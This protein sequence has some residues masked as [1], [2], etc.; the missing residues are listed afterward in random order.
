MR[1]I[2]K[3]IY[4]SSVTTSHPTFQLLAQEKHTLPSESALSFIYHL[5][6]QP[7]LFLLQPPANRLTGLLHDYHPEW[8]LLSSPRSNK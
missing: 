3:L 5:I 7:Q 6:I 2:F 4:C 8:I 1:Y